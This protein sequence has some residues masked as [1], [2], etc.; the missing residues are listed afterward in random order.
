MT[1]AV[2]AAAATIA[3]AG[4]HGGD[5]AG[6]AANRIQR[7][8]RGAELLDHPGAPGDLRHARIPGR[9]STTQS[10]KNLTEALSEQAADPGRLFSD[11]LCWNG[12]NGCAGDVRLYDW[13][14]NGY[15][16]VQKV[17]FT[18]RDGATLSGRV[19][20]TKAGPEARGPGS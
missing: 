18:A 14:K 11:D 20:A 9:S 4:N 16:L 3:I 7:R 17:L 19:W 1:K 15:G 6:G 10:A 12:G 2:R 8:H 13:Q 5:R